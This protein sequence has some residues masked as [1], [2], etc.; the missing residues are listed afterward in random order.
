MQASEWCVALE[1][2]RQN[3]LSF[4]ERHGLPWDPEWLSRNYLDKQ[5]YMVKSKQAATVGFVS[6]EP[7]SSA[8]HIHT[9]QLHSTVQN[10]R[11][12][13]YVLRELLAVAAQFHLAAITCCVFNDHP[14]R[15]MYA[16][17]GF[18]EVSAKGV[19][20]SLEVSTAH[21]RLAD[22]LRQ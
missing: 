11:V 13:M 12:G 3:M 1:L 6:V 17:L 5:N 22:I 16:R 21:E 14:A 8:L 7:T 10:G 2:M 15:G 9:L 19:L 18:R 20:V 4:H